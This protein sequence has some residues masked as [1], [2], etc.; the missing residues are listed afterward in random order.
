MRPWG[1]SAW[2]SRIA[3]VW[4]L[5]VS[6]FGIGLPGARAHPATSF[7][8][9]AVEPG[10]S[11]CTDYVVYKLGDT[12]RLRGHVKPPHANLR[13]QV[14]RRLPSGQA[15]HRVGTVDVSARGWMHY[16]WNTTERTRTAEAPYRIQ[17]RIPGHGRSRVV[18]LFVLFR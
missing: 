11:T 14:W 6:F 3:A 7:T 1:R 2:P 5:A 10:N 18:H 17:F 9:C 15:F 8:A 16:A 13:A 4:L 12:V